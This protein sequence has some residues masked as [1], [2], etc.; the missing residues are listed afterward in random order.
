MKTTNILTIF[1]LSALFSF[2]GEEEKKPLDLDAL[3]SSFIEEKDKKQMA[4]PE[5]KKGVESAM[6]DL[7]KKIIRYD[8]VGEPSGIEQ[9]LKEKAKADFGIEVILHGCNRPARKDFYKGYKNTI[10]AFLKKKHG[11][12][13]IVIIAKNLSTKQSAELQR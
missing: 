7:S 11:F 6:A 5:Y 10:L 8:L 1:I 13:P 2:A 12:D 4:L 3:F 9:K